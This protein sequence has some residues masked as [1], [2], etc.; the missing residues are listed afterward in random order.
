MPSTIW[1]PTNTSRDVQ[2]VIVG[3][4]AY[5][6]SAGIPRYLTTHIRAAV[7]TK[8]AVTGTVTRHPEV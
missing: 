1:K 4:N 8:L 5:T 6:F 7:E 2:T 3:E